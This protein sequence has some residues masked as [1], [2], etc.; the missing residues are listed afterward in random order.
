[1]SIK[2]KCL[3]VIHIF[4][5][6]T[7][8]ADDNLAGIN[9]FSSEITFP[10]GNGNNVTA[11]RISGTDLG[12]TNFSWIGQLKGVNGGFASLAMVDDWLNGTIHLPEGVT[13]AIRGR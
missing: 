7:A 1:M 12:G 8:F 3:L 10:L 5:T 9:L 4:F 2:L 6:T 13:Y 11:K